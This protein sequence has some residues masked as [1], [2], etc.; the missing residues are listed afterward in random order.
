MELEKLIDVSLVA[1]ALGVAPKRVYELASRNLLPSVRLG[2]QIKFRASQ[3]QAWI[4]AGGVKLPGGW[5]RE[6][7]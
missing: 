6:A 3:I 1:E 7:P 4:E 5:R 2:R